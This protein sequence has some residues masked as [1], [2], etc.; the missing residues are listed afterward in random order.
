MAQDYDD[1][2]CVNLLDLPKELGMS[3]EEA[4]TLIR[5]RIL[6]RNNVELQKVRNISFT[7]SMFYFYEVD[8]LKPT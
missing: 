5:T 7:K 8:P 4:K 2:I 1:F 6:G 3:L